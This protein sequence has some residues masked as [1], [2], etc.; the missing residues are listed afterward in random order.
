MRKQTLYYEWSGGQWNG[1]VYA[2]GNNVYVC[3]LVYEDGN[4]V[5]VGHWVYLE[6]RLPLNASELAGE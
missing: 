5:H 4:N 6:Q 1:W 3:H 2:D